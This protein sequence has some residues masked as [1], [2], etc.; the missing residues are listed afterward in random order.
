M[1]TTLNNRRQRTAR[2]RCPRNYSSGAGAA[3]QHPYGPRRLLVVIV[4]GLCSSLPAA[5]AGGRFDTIPRYGKDSVARAPARGR[6]RGEFVSSM[7]C[8]TYSFTVDVE[9]CRWSMSLTPLTLYLPEEVDLPPGVG[10][11]AGIS[12]SWTTVVASD[13]HE[14]CMVLRGDSSRI[15]AASGHAGSRGRPFLR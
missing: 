2:F 12:R 9:G 11:G 14:F 6:V 3:P 7:E 4:G 13:G 5:W 1:T 10:P 15:P 8:S